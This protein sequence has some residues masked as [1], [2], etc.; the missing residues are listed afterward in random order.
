MLIAN[1]ARAAFLA[2]LTAAA[3]SGAGSMLPIDYI[4]KLR[5]ANGG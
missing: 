5:A 4:K 1:T 2:C 3:V